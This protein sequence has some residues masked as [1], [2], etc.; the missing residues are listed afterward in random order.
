MCYIVDVTMFGGVG[1]VK[2][3]VGFI[4]RRNSDA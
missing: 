3:P 2:N 1:A 4:S